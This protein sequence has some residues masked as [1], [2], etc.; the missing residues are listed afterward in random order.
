M[1]ATLKHVAGRQGSTLARRLQKIRTACSRSYV[2]AGY[3]A[4]VSTPAAIAKAYKNEFGAGRT[5]DLDKPMPARPFMAMAIP[6][7]VY[8][9]RKSLP[10]FHV[11]QPEEF[12]AS[13]GAVMANGIRES[14][15][16]GGFR[17]NAPY[18]LSQK[19]GDKPLVD[20]GE[21][22]AEAAFQVRATA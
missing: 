16:L 10:A 11:E 6:D 5:S 13:A 4:G 9:M 8:A 18:T 19:R 21:M 12:L 1:G 22:Q 15:D 20:S 14:I 17:P 3:I 2:V 7:I